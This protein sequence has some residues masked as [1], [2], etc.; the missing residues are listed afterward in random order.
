M[1]STFIYP[2]IY[3]KSK[4]EKPFPVIYVANHVSF[5][6][7]FISGSVLDGYPRGL[8]LKSHFDKPIYGWFITRFGEIPLD[9]KNKHSI[10]ES[11]L[12]MA[13][14]LKNRERCI[15]IMPEGT[16]TRDGKIG[17]FKIGAFHLSKISGIPIVP[18]VFKKLYEKN[19]PNSFLITPGKFEVHILDKID[20][21]NFETDDAISTY[22]KEVME[23]IL[24]S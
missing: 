7:L 12:S 20:P 2:K 8:E 21:N 6:D 15:L 17:K 5:F 1:Y 4:N 24:E 10:K 11:F 19:N 22:T 3:Y 9:T 13:N 14:I 18:V 16:R 23:K